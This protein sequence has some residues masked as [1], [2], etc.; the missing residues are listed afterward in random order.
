[1]TDNDQL[2][3]ILECFK[4]KTDIHFPLKTRSV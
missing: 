2:P 1:M 4:P 3:K